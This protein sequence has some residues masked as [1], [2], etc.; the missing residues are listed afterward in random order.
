MVGLVVFSGTKLAIISH[1][2]ITFP[3]KNRPTCKITHLCTS[4][5][6]QSLKN[7]S[8]FSFAD[9]TIKKQPKNLHISLIF[10]IF[11]VSKRKGN[12]NWEL[13]CMR[14]PTRHSTSE[15]IQ[16]SLLHSTTERSYRQRTIVDAARKYYFQRRGTTTSNGNQVLLPTAT[17]Y[18]LAPNKI[19]SI[20]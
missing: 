14:N 17:G 11:A 13:G 20:N 18:N 16:L 7:V 4:K 10:R 12:E 9:N 19:H 2:P 1:S 3:E 5:T 6:Q 15:I 8:M